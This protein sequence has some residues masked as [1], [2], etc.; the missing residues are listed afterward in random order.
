M[1]RHL[2]LVC[3]GN[4]AMA[5]PAARGA[6]P[7]QPAQI[8]GPRIVAEGGVAAEGIGAGTPVMTLRGAVAVEHLLPGDR[9]ITRD[10]GL[11]EL[12]ENRMRAAAGPL[13][14][15]A[16]GALGADRPDAVL[17]VP[18]TQPVLVRDWRAQARFGKPQ[19]IVPAWR[20]VDGGDI[21]LAMPDAPLTL[22]TLVLDAAHVL[23]AGGVELLSA[24]RTA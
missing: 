7:T 5:L 22:H 18:R 12:R 19:A 1:T 20:L 14:R 23:Y 4:T 21:A 16:P 8:A 11:C 13:V 3:H 15:I 17:W 10:R 2:T 24:A 9:I 6:R